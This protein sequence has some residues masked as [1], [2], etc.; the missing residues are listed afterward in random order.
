VVTT[1]GLLG[2]GIGVNQLLRLK[3]WLKNSPPIVS[4]DGDAAEPPEED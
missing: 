2:I 1:L 4:S 3:R